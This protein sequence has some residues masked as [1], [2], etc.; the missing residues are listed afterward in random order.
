MQAAHK[1]DQT[2]FFCLQFLV[3]QDKIWDPV[4]MSSELKLKRRRKKIKGDFMA[5]VKRLRFT[6]IESEGNDTESLS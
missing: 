6:S 1:I 4:K 5:R 2:L 3:C